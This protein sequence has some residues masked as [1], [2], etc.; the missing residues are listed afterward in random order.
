MTVKEVKYKIGA[1]G[2][3]ITDRS[4]KNVCLTYEEI[5]TILDAL[6]DKELT[7]DLVEELNAALEHKDTIFEA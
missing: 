7:W 6:D 2:K 5:G 4:D 1:D 3:P